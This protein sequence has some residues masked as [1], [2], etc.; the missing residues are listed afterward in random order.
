MSYLALVLLKMGRCVAPCQAGGIVQLLPH[1]QRLL[2]PSRSFL[3]RLSLAPHPTL[4]GL[5]TIL[6]EVDGCGTVMATGSGPGTNFSN[7]T[8]G[9]GA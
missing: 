2:L 3:S 7:K 1:R 5:A 8:K 4:L 9:D 6:T